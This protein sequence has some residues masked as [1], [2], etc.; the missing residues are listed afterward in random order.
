MINPQ[1]KG[2][3]PTMFIC[4]NGEAAK[5]LVGEILNQFGRERADMCKAEASRHRAVVHAVVHSTLSSQRLDARLRLLTN[6]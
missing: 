5:N 6:P 3:K 4:G 2:G 1:F